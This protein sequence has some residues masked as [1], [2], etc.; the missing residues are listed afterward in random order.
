MVCE[1]VK[2]FICFSCNKCILNYIVNVREFQFQLNKFFLKRRVYI[3]YCFKHLWNAGGHY[4][5]IPLRVKL[6]S[7][8]CTKYV[9]VQM[10]IQISFCLFR[11]KLNVL[12]LLLLH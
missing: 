2:S 3:L 7:S 1:T 9:G 6:T 10:S 11:V 8:H 5:S 4:K 12:K